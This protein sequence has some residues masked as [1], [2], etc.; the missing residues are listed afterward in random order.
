MGKEETHFT[1]KSKNL[2]LVSMKSGQCSSRIIISLDLLQKKNNNTVKIQ[3]KKSLSN[4]LNAN[5]TLSFWVFFWCYVHPSSAPFCPHV[6]VV[7]LMVHGELCGVVN[8][9]CSLPGGM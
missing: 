9:Q 1:D 8:I 7:I 2:C 5:H 4:N 3:G 6:N